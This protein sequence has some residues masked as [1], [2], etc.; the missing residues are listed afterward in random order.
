MIS[1]SEEEDDSINIGKTDNTLV[2]VNEQNG[3]EIFSLCPHSY[4]TCIFLNPSA[5]RN[6]S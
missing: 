3:M 6:I 5:R 1:G 2:L 4:L